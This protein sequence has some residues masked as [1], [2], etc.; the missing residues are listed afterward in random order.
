MDLLKDIQDY[1]V[2][3]GVAERIFRDTIDDSTDEAIAIYEY[4][5]DSPIIATN[6]SSRSIQIVTRSSKNT[7][8]VAR[9]RSKTI[10]KLFETENGRINFTPSRWA[11]IHVRHAPFAFKTDEA[12]R[13]YY[14][15]NIGVLTYND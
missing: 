15:F 12:G 1:L 4:Q 2:A 6:V 10:H 13:K 11:V 14:T 5:G 8:S 3:N 7:P 9:T